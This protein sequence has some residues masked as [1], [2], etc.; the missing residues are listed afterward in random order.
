MAIWYILRSFGN[1]VIIWYIFHRLYEKNL[2]TLRRKAMY[3][4][5]MICRVNNPLS[6][7]THSNAN[8]AKLL[9]V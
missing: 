6:A 5:K 1:V 8:Q 9:Q 3:D 2:A 7:S 4:A